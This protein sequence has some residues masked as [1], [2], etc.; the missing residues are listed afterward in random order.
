MAVK[1]TISFAEG[2]LKSL[3]ELV[4]KHNRSSFV[5]N[6]VAYALELVAKEKAIDALYSFP[7]VK[8]DGKPVVE[9]LQDIRK[10]ESDKSVDK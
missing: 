4:P 6:A 2:T 7:R 10:L 1:R 9:V 3:E 5:N 8:G